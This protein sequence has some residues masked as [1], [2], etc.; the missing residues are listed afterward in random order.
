MSVNS[1]IVD[2][3]FNFR[4]FT[5]AMEFVPGKHDG[6]TTAI[7]LALVITRFGITAQQ[8]GGITTDDGS[9][10]AP[11][12]AQFFSEKEFQLGA[13]SEMDS[14]RHLRCMGHVLNNVWA[15]ACKEVAANDKGRKHSAT[16]LFVIVAKVRLVIFY[17]AQS[18]QRRA[19]LQEA[20]KAL[21]IVAKVVMFPVSTRWWADLFMLHRANHLGRALLNVT[22][23]QMNL[24][25]AKAAKYVKILSDFR[26]VLHLL[27]H[28]IEIGCVW[29]KWQ[30]RLS[31]GTS[32]TLSRYSK[33]LTFYLYI[34][35]DSLLHIKSPL[36]KPP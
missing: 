8:I 16:V 33:C 21:N 5:L 17:Y 14:R 18:S 32:V 34:F 27:P 11:G 19:A 31:S 7:T 36:L 24:S 6:K 20:C 26:A 4:E 28:I 35:R 1:S 29:E 10:M 2:K 12:V 15:D 13:G 30:S 3:D 25:G 22:S 9:A 23:K